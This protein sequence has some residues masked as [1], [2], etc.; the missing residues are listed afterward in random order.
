MIKYKSWIGGVLLFSLILLFLS[1]GTIY[2][3]SSAN[4][5][6]K[7][8]VADQGG[9][10]SQ[11]TNFKLTDA[12]GQPSPL[13]VA[14]SANYKIASGFFAG[15]GTPLTPVLS[16]SPTTLDFG[17]SNTTMQFQITNTGDGTLTWTVTENPDKA[18]ITD[19]TPSS[20]DGDATV[21]VT[22]DR[23]QLSGDTDSGTLL[24]A[25]NGGDQN[26][27]VNISGIPPTLPPWTY[28]SPTSNSATVIL[29][30]DA[31][32]NI[33]GTPL[34]NGDWV[35]VFTPAG[36]CCGYEQWQGA[37]IGIT[38]WGD[39]NQTTEIDGFQAGEIIYYRV[40]R[41][42]ES[43]EWTSVIV[44]YSQGDGIY[45]ANGYFVLS[46][47]DAS[48]N[49]T[50]MLDFAQGWNMF[51]INVDPPD[52]NMETIM[53]PIN[54]KLVLVKNGV[55]ENY[56][57]KYGINQIGDINYKDGYQA[58]L[59]EAATLDVTGAAVN[60]GT[61]IDLPAGW[62]LIS[63]LPTVPIPAPTALATIV[64]HL[65]IAKDGLGNNYDPYYGINQIG[66]MR[67][68]QGY[69]VYLDAPAT[70][71][72]PSSPLLTNESPDDDEEPI[73]IRKTTLEYFQF[74]N[75]TGESATV[76]VPT[77]AE[78][79]YSDDSSLETG[80]EI[81]VFTTDGLCCGAVVWESANTAIT[82]WGDDSQTD[83]IDGFKANDTL[84]YR[85]WKKSTN[86]EYSATVTYE[87]GHPVVYTTN[88]YSVLTSLVAKT[89]TDIVDADKSV[90]PSEYQL[91]QNYPNPFN[92]ETSIEFQLPQMAKVKLTIYDLQGHVVTQLINDT[93][94]P[95]FHSLKWN[96]KDASGR[97]VASGMYL[98]QIE[99]IPIDAKEKPF[100]NVKKMILMK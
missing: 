13:G 20:G 70:L 1:A 4:Y 75:G 81:G 11:S 8:S 84:R 97:T 34:Q 64:D 54:D 95:G 6:I 47:F 61:P 49:A 60:P 91:L 86:E 93:K 48:E 22:V 41:T 82:V 98:Y 59:T 69:Q 52:P 77:S 45:T 39:D 28:T 89:I 16:V 57:P 85:V 71:I 31:N 88:G 76:I 90:I 18:W 3:Q 21:T 79:K 17:A 33:E 83:S 44:E 14:T 65:I 100:L 80:D 7:K 24:V 55:G 26:V 87:N 2:A 12:V 53:A 66:D 68:G 32:P 35:G 46:K 58:Y 43:K 51:S 10:P 5:K 9:A 74:S 67:P 92:P 42:T 30:T 29:P 62:S 23:S 78:P 36:L 56:D 63:Y 38:A 15:G 37:S 19:I 73:T 25:S 40:Y 94:S 96:A 27:T 72:Y 99:I 50:I